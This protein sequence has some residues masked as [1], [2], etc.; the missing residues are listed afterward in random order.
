MLRSAKDFV[1]LGSILAPCNLAA[2]VL[3][4][5]ANVGETVAH[6]GANHTEEGSEE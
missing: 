4:V 1:L 6:V 5:L 2:T 3:A